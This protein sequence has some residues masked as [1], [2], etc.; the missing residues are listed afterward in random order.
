MADKILKARIKLLYKTWQEWQEQ[1]NL[2]MVPLKG[3]ACIVYAPAGSEQSLTE[4]ALLMKIGDGE[5]KFRNLPWLQAIASDVHDWAK[6]SALAWSDLSEDFKAQ[7]AGYVGAGNEYRLNKIGEAYTLQVRKYDATTESWGEW[8][9]VADSTIDISNKTDRVLNGPNGKALIFNESDGGGVKFE[10][11]DGTNSFVGVNDGGENGLNGQIY[12]INS[13]NKVGARINIT[14]KGIFYTNGKDTP[15]Y[16]TND[17]IATKGDISA[18]GS[19][20]HYIGMT[21]AVPGE[22]VQQALAR[23]VAAYQDS[24]PGYKLKEGAV[25][26][27]DLAEFIY[28]GEGWQEFGDVSLYATKAELEAASAELQT[29][30]E[31]EQTARIAEDAK[32]VDKEINSASGKALIFNESDGGGAKFEHTDG[33]NSYVGVNNGGTNGLAAQIYAVDKDS[34]VGTRINITKG[35]IYYTNGRS[36]Y[37]DQTADDEIATKGDIAGAIEDIVIIDGNL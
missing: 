14:A 10:H 29:L 7:L 8:T 26:I 31:A 28:N 34:N 15:A 19:A 25:A 35:A 27:V 9:D 24:H 11:N 37:R 2:D 12:A 21:N 33:T 4:P 5:T 20:L 16:D 17:E 1:A 6:K 18:L 36:S 23:I 3:E 13:V 30:I 32:K 22:T